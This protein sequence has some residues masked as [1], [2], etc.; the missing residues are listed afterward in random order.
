MVEE[1]LIEHEICLKLR[2][3]NPTV[4]SRA[5]YEARLLPPEIAFPVITEAMKRE[6]APSVIF[7]LVFALRHLPED[8]RNQWIAGLTPNS[9]QHVLWAVFSVFAHVDG[10]QLPD[11]LLVPVLTSGR[12]PLA[13]ACAEYCYIRG[14]QIAQA[15]RS[16]R[17]MAN[18]LRECRV[19]VQSLPSVFEGT[20]FS[21]R[22]AG[23]YAATLAAELEGGSTDSRRRTIR[24]ITPG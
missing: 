15:T 12:W 9:N 21:A 18:A 2:S 17:S 23:H 4:R 7:V 3:P 20:R 6:R 19:G 13:L 8:L 16:L 22:D 5:A 11:S 10:S 24:L 1:K 14:V